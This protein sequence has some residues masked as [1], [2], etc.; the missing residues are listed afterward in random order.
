MKHDP[1]DY[2]KIKTGEVDVDG[3]ITDRKNQKLRITTWLDGDIY[4]ELKKRA[5]A[6]EGKGRYQTL[7]NEVLREALL[8]AS[9]EELLE[10]LHIKGIIK[11]ELRAYLTNKRLKAAMMNSRKREPH[12]KVRVSRAARKRA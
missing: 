3:D 4:D 9:R 6:G 11:N 2:S 7:M 1:N 12:R 5:D 10:G 8:E